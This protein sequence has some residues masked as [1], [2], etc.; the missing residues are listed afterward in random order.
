MKSSAF[1]LNLA[2]GGIVNE[3]ALLQALTD[4]KLAGAGIDVHEHEGEGKVSPLAKLPNVILTPHIGAGTVDTQ[5]AIGQEMIQLITA[6]AA[7]R[8]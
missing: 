4:G 2:R 8:G 7:A 5:R 3:Q 6:H 1:L